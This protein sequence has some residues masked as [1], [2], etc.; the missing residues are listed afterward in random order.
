MLHCQLSDNLLAGPS[1][2]WVAKVLKAL[3]IRVVAVKLVGESE[4]VFGLLICMGL[5]F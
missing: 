3:D 2:A 1:S 4:M 5:P